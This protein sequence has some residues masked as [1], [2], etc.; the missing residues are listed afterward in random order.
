MSMYYLLPVQIY[1][2]LKFQ[3]NL[4]LTPVHGLPQTF[5]DVTESSKLN[6]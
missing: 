4:Y 5:D 3:K 2:I 1:F 6:E